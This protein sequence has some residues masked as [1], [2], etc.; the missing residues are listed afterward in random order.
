MDE[1]V[2]AR[3]NCVYYYDVPQKCVIVF[4]CT[5]VRIHEIYEILQT[6]DKIKPINIKLTID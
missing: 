3:E 1:D 5:W 2:C 6:I 4:I